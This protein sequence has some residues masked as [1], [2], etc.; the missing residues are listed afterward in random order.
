[1][2]DPAYEMM[3]IPNWRPRERVARFKEYVEIVDQLLSNNVTT[4]TGR[5]YKV[6]GAVM[7]PPPVQKPRPPIT[8]AAWKPQMMRYAAR[9]ADTW[10]TISSAATFEE[11]LDEIRDRNQLVDEYC[12]DIGREPSS[13]RRSIMLSD[14]EARARGGFIN[15]YESV[16]VFV[17]MVE[18]FIEIGV[19]EFVI[20]YPY[21]EEQLPM[22]ERIAR[23]AIPE[24]KERYNAQG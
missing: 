17:E 20:H 19:S 21:R 5:Y 2:I 3:G 18:K 16:D 10:N 23:E 8:V 15:Y 22:F 7:N 11:Q 1:L 13:L 4:Y 24:L 6:K 12:Q 14:S 9:Y